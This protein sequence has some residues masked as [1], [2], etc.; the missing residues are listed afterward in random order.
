MRDP[1]DGLSALS[2]VPGGKSP[3]ALPL[4]MLTRRQPA[5]GV[6]ETR[7]RLLCGD[8]QLKVAGLHNGPLGAA[9]ADERPA[10]EPAPIGGSG[11]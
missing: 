7:R 6:P 10:A 3:A 5:V 8:A 11:S 4:R 2:A 1:A 9:I